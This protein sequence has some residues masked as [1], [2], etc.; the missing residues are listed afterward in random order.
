METSILDKYNAGLIPSKTNATTAAIRQVNA[1]H[2]P[3]TKIKIGGHSGMRPY[4][5]KRLPTCSVGV[6]PCLVRS[7]YPYGSCET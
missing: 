6:S 7:C 5:M 4:G 2:S 1:Q 3:L